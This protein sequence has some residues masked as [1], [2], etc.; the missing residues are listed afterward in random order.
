MDLTLNWESMSYIA[1]PV[2]ICLARII[3]V[4]IGTLRVIFLTKGY[5]LIAPVLGFFEIL[6]WL[7]AIGQ[8][9]QNLTDIV[10]YLAYA[11]GFA[12]GN[13]VGIKI[14]Q[15][16]ALGIVAVRIVTRKEA[17]DLIGFLKSANFGV[18]VIPAEGATGPVHVL[19]T[20]IKRTR[21]YEV[22]GYIKKY[23]PKAFYTVEDIRFVSE[24]IFPKKSVFLRPD[25]RIIPAAKKEK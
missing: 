19:F 4:S 1:I 22:V 8:V 10:N 23:N 3:D 2:L 21:L 24:G 9:M 15:K 16:L 18:T 25:V 14:E 11:V 7:T 20:I 5:K 6:I 17:Y 12:I 13:Y